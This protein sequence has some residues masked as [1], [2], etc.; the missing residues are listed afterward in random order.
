MAATGGRGGEGRM[1]ALQA[2]RPVLRV[3]GRGGERRG[4]VRGWGSGPLIWRAQV[5]MSVRHPTPVPEWDTSGT[6][7][8]CSVP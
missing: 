8:L 5:D 6:R 2:L 4:A 7:T 3:V 1:E